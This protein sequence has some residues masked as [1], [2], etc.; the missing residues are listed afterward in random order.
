MGWYVTNTFIPVATFDFA[1]CG[2]FAV[3][4]EDEE[5]MNIDSRFLRQATPGHADETIH[6]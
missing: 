3:F 1:E 4:I 2:N 5:F 6:L